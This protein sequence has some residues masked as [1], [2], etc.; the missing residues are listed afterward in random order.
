MKTNS[1]ITQHQGSFSLN[2][3]KSLAFFIIIILAGTTVFAQQQGQGQGQGWAN[4]TPEDRAKRQ[5]DMMKT[6][7]NLTAAQEPKVA[8]INLRYAKKMEDIR[9]ISDTAVQHKSAKNLQSQKDKEL[10]G[11]LTEAQFKDY[12]KMMEDM[13]NRHH[14]APHQQ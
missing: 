6:Q 10:K 5:T 14:E 1:S 2:S 7:L 13:R 3:L 12:Q 11:V 8:D 4:A 9:K